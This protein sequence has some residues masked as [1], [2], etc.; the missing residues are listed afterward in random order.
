MGSEGYLLRDSQVPSVIQDRTGTQDSKL[1]DV[2]PSP[3]SDLFICWVGKSA[4]VVFFLKKI[5][6]QLY[7]Q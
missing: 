6:I 3:N 5:Y 7:M 4:T 1:L 2:Y